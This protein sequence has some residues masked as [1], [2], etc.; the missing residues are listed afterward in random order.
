MK[1]DTQFSQNDDEEDAWGSLAEDLFG[2]ELDSQPVIQE[3]ITPKKEPIEP[4]AS[5][6]D[7]EVTEPEA[8]IS[9]PV[10]EEPARAEIAA[11]ETEEADDQ[12]FDDSD[13]EESDRDSEDPFWNALAEW[14]WDNGSLSNQ[15]SGNTSSA[16]K[17]TRKPRAVDPPRNVLDK[18]TPDIEP[19]KPV[20]EDSGF[21]DDIFDGGA[22]SEDST[23]EVSAEDSS[24]QASSEQSEEERARAVVA[25]AAV[26]NLKGKS[27]QK[28]LNPLRPLRK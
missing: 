7:D 12:T 26:D 11:V 20:T 27:R 18:L 23:A 2:D 9:E 22:S 6:T 21:A 19:E 8:E 5:E 1:K 10:V 16:E 25:V 17:R 4:A 28:L 24:E 14:D 3:E 13:D 15:D